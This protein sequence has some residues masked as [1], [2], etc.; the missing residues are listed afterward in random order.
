M[1]ERI[2][3]YLQLGKVTKEQDEISLKT[4]TKLPTTMMKSEKKGTQKIIDNL[5]SNEGKQNKEGEVFEQRYCVVDGQ[6]K[7]ADSREDW[8]EL[9]VYRGTLYIVCSWRSGDENDESLMKQPFL[10]K[11]VGET[12]T[13]FK[14][15]QVCRDCVGLNDI[16]IENQQS[17]PIR[18]ESLEI[19]RQP[20]S[21]PTIDNESHEVI[22]KDFLDRQRQKLSEKRKADYGKLRM[23]TLIEESHQR[24]KE[25][26]EQERLDRRARDRDRFRQLSIHITDSLDE[27]IDENDPNSDSS[28][29]SMMPILEK[30][31]LSS[32]TSEPKV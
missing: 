19:N 14:D 20:N 4:S 16:E 10:L 11:V 13:I 7:M 18:K 30:P 2:K 5:S 22:K 23:H 3:E 12:P 9:V 27:F 29:S 31:N 25:L 6:V 28:N 32:I 24:K 17:R 26:I 1:V 21:L 15:N 8:G